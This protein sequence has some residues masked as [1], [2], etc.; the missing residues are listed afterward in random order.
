MWLSSFFLSSLRKETKVKFAKKLWRQKMKKG[1]ERS[2]M[3]EQGRFWQGPP[4][5]R[6]T[7][8]WDFVDP[9]LISALIFC[10]VYL[11]RFLKPLCADVM[12]GSPP[13]WSGPPPCSLPFSHSLPPNSRF[14]VC[15]KSSVRFFKRHPPPPRRRSDSTLREPTAFR[16]LPC[17]GHVMRYAKEHSFAGFYLW[18]LTVRNFWF[19]FQI[20]RRRRPGD[21]DGPSSW[22]VIRSDV[23]GDWEWTTLDT[24]M[25]NQIE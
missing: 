1:R 19:C 23:R 13:I 21:E 14:P 18:R 12:H 10:T 16:F 20:R 22:L 17:L 24:L 4:Y 8:F 15:Q 5:M 7:E 3:E 11:L 6:S 2:R 9:L 25:S